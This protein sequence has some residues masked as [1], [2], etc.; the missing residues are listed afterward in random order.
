MES[1]FDRSM[2]G[3]IRAAQRM[4]GSQLTLVPNTEWKDWSIYRLEAH[5]G[6]ELKVY[7]YAAIHYLWNGRPV[8][9][10]RNTEEER[11]LMKKYRIEAPLPWIAMSEQA[12]Q[13]ALAFAQD[14]DKK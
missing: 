7:Y 8:A 2:P 6:L 9:T 12:V 1:K 3:F 5:P 4:L 11:Y 13:E 14:L 10:K